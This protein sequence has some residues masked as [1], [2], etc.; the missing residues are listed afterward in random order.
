LLGVMIFSVSRASHF[1]FLD[2]VGA[3]LGNLFVLA[4]ARLI[5]KVILT[6]WKSFCLPCMR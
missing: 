1:V 5:K 2:L 4:C 3:I 6:R